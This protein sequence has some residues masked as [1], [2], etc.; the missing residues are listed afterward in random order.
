MSQSQ[1]RKPNQMKKWYSPIILRDYEI[2]PMNVA[3]V[4]EVKCATS[5]EGVIINAKFIIHHFNGGAVT[6]ISNAMNY[7]NKEVFN[8]PETSF[9][10]RLKLRELAGYQCRSYTENLRSEFL[11]ELTERCAEIAAEQKERD[12]HGAA[13]G[14]DDVWD[15]ILAQE[16]EDNDK[17]QGFISITE[18]QPQNNVRFV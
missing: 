14:Y 5:P 2:D 3:E 8:N 6:I 18:S 16:K 15:E 4:D 7:I 11:E 9:E 1:K 10:E 12:K 17:Y 13:Y